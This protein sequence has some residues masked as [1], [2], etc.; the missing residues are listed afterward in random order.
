MTETQNP[1][2]ALLADLAAKREAAGGPVEFSD[3]KFRHARAA[4]EKPSPPKSNGGPRV[5]ASPQEELRDIGETMYSPDPWIPKMAK[6]LGEHP[7]QVRRWM[8]GEATMPPVVLHRARLA[9]KN[10]VARL[11]RLLVRL[12]DPGDDA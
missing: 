8:N 11:N 5:Y 7:R 6:D 12:G 10:Q 2:D 9:I 3:R 1:A 4:S